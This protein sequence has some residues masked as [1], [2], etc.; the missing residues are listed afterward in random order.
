M[1]RSFPGTNGNLFTVGDVA[2]MD[3]TGLYLTL[4]AWVKKSAAG[5]NQFVLT[6]DNGTTP[7]GQW[8]I[9]CGGATEGLVYDS[10]GF[11]QIIGATTIPVGQWHHIALVKEGTGAGALRCYLNGKLDG[12]ATSN[13]TIQNTASAVVIGNR[14]ANDT[15]MNGHLAHIAAWASSLTP[16]EIMLLA[17]GASPLSI[18]PRRLSGYWPLEDYPGSPAG[19]AVDLTQYRSNGTL[20]GSVGYV[21]GPYLPYLLP[22]HFEIPKFIQASVHHQYQVVSV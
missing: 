20:S 1:A 18:Q 19:G 12:S 15:P 16:F 10:G 14:A 7:G 9:T 21:P 8:R 4:A 5:G 13:R 6:K 22:G 2:P 17:Q 11:D 3:I